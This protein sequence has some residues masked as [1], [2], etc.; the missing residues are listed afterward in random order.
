MPAK[1]NTKKKVVK[2]P[3]AGG[4]NVGGSVRHQGD[5]SSASNNPKATTFAQRV[6]IALDTKN[7]SPYDLEEPVGLGAHTVYKAGPGTAVETARLIAEAT[8][9]DPAWLLTGKGEPFPLPHPDSPEAHARINAAWDQLLIA[10]TALGK[11]VAKIGPL[12]PDSKRDELRLAL[13]RVRQALDLPPSA[14]S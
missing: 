2:R 13:E 1:R 9:C 12:V 8:G 10:A 5:K 14:E 7:L 6:R 3:D 4:S 11:A